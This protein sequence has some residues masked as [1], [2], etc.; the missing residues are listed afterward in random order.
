MIR[1]L[2]AV[3]AS[4]VIAQTGTLANAEVPTLTAEDFAQHPAVTS[5]SMSIE[6]D[7]LVGIVPDPT[8]PENTAAA[9]WDLSGEIDTSGIFGAVRDHPVR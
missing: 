7:M 3:I 1:R 5:V 6:G 4:L 9:Y 8:D 2:S